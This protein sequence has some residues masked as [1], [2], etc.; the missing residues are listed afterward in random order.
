[1]KCSIIDPPSASITSRHPFSILLI[2]VCMR[3][4]YMLAK[5]LCKMRWNSSKEVSSF[6]FLLAFRLML[7][8]RF[9]MAGD[10]V[11]GSCR[12]FHTLN[13]ISSRSIDRPTICWRG[14]GAARRAVCS[15]HRRRVFLYG[16]QCK[17]SS[18]SCRR[19]VSGGKWHWA[20]GM[21][22]WSAR[23]PGCNPIEN[24]WDNIKRKANMKV[25]DDTSLEQF[26][27]ILQ[28]AWANLDQRRIQTL[29]NS[30]LK[31]CREVIEA[32]GGP[33]NYW[34][35]HSL[36]CLLKV[37]HRVTCNKWCLKVQKHAWFSCYSCRSWHKSQKCKIFPHTFCH[38]MHDF[39]PTMPSIGR[40][41]PF[42]VCVRKVHIHY[43]LNDQ[44]R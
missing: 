5:A 29:I 8:Q 23:S 27:R 34:T 11:G 42:I 36:W 10:A 28:R 30:M 19:S 35:L 39:T 41:V 40:H 22:E 21:D 15:S 32:D 44:N 6:T 38:K 4:W 24:L 17:T 43:R 26:Q 25:K 9:S 1:M 14:V 33:I 13:A 16:R 31:R 20:Y 7:S 12:P 37:K 2:K 3:R 18:C